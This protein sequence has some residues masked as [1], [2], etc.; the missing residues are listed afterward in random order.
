MKL[1]GL[2]VLLGGLAGLVSSG[3]AV[4]A[5]ANVAC[6]AAIVHHEPNYRLGTL[7]GGPWFRAQPRRTR[8]L[9]YMFGGHEVSGRFRLYAGPEDPN[10]HSAQKVLWI[11]KSG[12]P[13]AGKL[14]ITG[15]RL[16]L[17]PHRVRPLKK[18]R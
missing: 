18:G 5:T 1:S 11:F 15:I 3:S 14:Q 10:T 12:S 8:V 2:L 9:G 4:T 17:G 13:A 16:R 7:S 6:P